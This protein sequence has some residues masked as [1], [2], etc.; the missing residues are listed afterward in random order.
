MAT[1]TPTRLYTTEELLAMPDDGVERWLVKG[2]LREKPPEIPGATMTVRNRFHSEVLL[3]IGTAIKTWIRTHP[4]PRGKVYGG[5]AGVRLPSSPDDSLGV[6]V[7]YA[8]PDV[9]LQQTNVRSTLVVGIPTLCVEIYSPND[10]IDQIQEKITTYLSAGVAIVWNVDPY[11]QTVTVYAAG[12]RPTMY[13]IDQQI[14][15][16]PAMP[17]FSPKVSE[18]FDD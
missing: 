1:A 7:A 10:T 3:N 12:H 2:Q 11:D 9:V 4:K 17:G 15:E 18:F 14:P 8:G 6:D 13:N 16:H 5:E